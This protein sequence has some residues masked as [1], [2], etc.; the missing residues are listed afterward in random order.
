MTITQEITNETRTYRLT[1]TT[2]LLGSN[3]AN[4][5]IHSEFVAAKAAT[6]QKALEET[7]M[8]PN[9]D[10]LREQLKEK[11]EQ[12][13]TM[14][15]TVFLR[16]GD[17]D[18]LVIGN[19]VVKGFLK[20][21]MLTLKDQLGIASPK[22]KV[23]NLVFVQP[24]YLPLMRDGKPITAPDDY[25]ERPLRAE[26][27]QGPRVSLASSEHINAPWYVDVTIKLIENSATGKS[28]PITW[29]TIETVLS[30]GAD[31][32]LGQW[33]NGGYGSFTVER[34]K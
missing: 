5:K 18:H 11:L 6:I 2:P 31:K 32:G 26:T 4:P 30:Y 21:A 1:G 13:K 23:D 15:L 33:R 22:S 8:L 12:I 28:K 14:G 16:D 24:T 19:H 27:M 9:E 34:L 10:E 20:S 3:P 29:D 7:N 25:N 17:D